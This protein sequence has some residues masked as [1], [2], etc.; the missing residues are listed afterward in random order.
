M[1]RKQIIKTLVAT[2]GEINIADV[3]TVLVTSEDPEHPV[4]YTFDGNGGRGGT[5]W[6][7]SE[8]GEQ[9]LILAF[10]SPQT[11]R[12]VFSGRVAVTLL[13]TLFVVTRSASPLTR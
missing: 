13:S 5:R 7:A 12:H 2:A 4:D 10:D 3:A 1:L 9:T 8:S 6:I 11:I